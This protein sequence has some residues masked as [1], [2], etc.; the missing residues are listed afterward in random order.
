MYAACPIKGEP[1]VQF[2]AE[3]GQLVKALEVRNYM[4]EQ[5]LDAV[6]NRNRCRVSWLFSCKCDC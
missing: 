6:E 4:E 3:R 1:M 2:V 5:V